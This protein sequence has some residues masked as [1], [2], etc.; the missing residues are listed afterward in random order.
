MSRTGQVTLTINGLTADWMSL[1]PEL[2][3][4]RDDP[5]RPG[6]WCW[7][8]RS[9]RGTARAAGQVVA[10]ATVMPH[11]GLTLTPAKPRVALVTGA[12]RGM[13]LETAR[14]LLERGLRVVMTGRDEDATER[15]RRTLGDAQHAVTVRLDVTDRSKY[16]RRILQSSL[17][18]VGTVDV[19]VNN[20]AV[21][22]FDDSDV[23]S[24]PP[25]GFQGT[26]D[27][28]VFGVIEVC[29]WSRRAM[30]GARRR[31]RRERVVP[32][33]SAV[34]RCQPMRRPMPSRK[35]R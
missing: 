16:H 5:P 21:L 20:A 28:N 13:G 2:F 25:E 32:C 8:G 35:P 6:T 9:G 7:S 33:R 10:S 22:L 4:V 17:R 30:G 19:L 26:F 14:Q 31:S 11:N 1:G 27:A 12:N 29:R 34:E 3:N 15:A 24:I 18:K 23:L